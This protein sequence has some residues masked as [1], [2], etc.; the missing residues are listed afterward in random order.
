MTLVYDSLQVAH[1]CILN[2]FY[3]YVMRKGARWR[4]MEMAGIVTLTGA[5]LITQ[6][7]EVRSDEERSDEERSDD[8]SVQLLLCGSLRSSL[9]QPP[10]RLVSLV[11]ARGADRPP[12]RARH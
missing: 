2:S 8:T 4:S 3:G 7:R 1:K 12:P 11:A 10:F 6:A 5:K 9:T